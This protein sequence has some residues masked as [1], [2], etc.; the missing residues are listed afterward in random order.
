MP[1]FL[2]PGFLMPGFWHGFTA[3]LFLFI[4]GKSISFAFLCQQY[5]PAG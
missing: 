4:V 3:S 2:M 1:G 5:T